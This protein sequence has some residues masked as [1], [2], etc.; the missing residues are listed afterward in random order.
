MTIGAAARGGIGT[1]LAQAPLMMPTHDA[2]LESDPDPMG[3]AEGPI[4]RRARG[5]FASEDALCLRWHPEVRAA[6][7]RAAGAGSRETLR[8]QREVEEALGRLLSVEHVMLLPSVSS[9]RFVSLAGFVEPNDHLLV[10]EEANPGLL[11]GARSVLDSALTYQHLDIEQ[12]HA[13][14]AELRA[15]SA[16]GRLLVATDSSFAHEAQSPSLALLVEVCARYDATLLVEMRGDLGTS[17][18]HGGGELERQGVLGAIDLVMGSFWGTL[19]S[20]LGFVAARTSGLLDSVRRRLAPRDGALLS[21]PELAATLESLRVLG[22]WEGR[23]LRHALSRNV[24]ALRWG[25]GRSSVT[26]L[27]EPSAVVPVPIEPVSAAR[28]AS[29]AL[30]RRGVSAPLWQGPHRG[31]PATRFLI[32]V[33]AAHTPDQ[34]VRVATLVAS[35]LSEARDADR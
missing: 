1:P 7:L 13:M 5:D 17:G 4:S 34:G 29:A 25:L 32:H 11:R 12:L 14:V 9:A 18:E 35:A 8:L 2:S 10:D 24:S 23:Q 20:S 22:S 33:S 30:G 28:R 26:P 21:A 6:F 27:G 3:T 15:R 31:R 16:T 19:A